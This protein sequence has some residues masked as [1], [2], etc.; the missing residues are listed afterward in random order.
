MLNM[1]NLLDIMVD[2]KRDADIGEVN[3]SLFIY[4]P[5]N[6]VLEYRI[7]RDGEEYGIQNEVNILQLMSSRVDVNDIFERRCRKMLAELKSYP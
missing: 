3:H 1:Q 7:I 6:L 4:D 2:A 5:L